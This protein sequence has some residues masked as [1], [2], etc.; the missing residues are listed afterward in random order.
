MAEQGPGG[1]CCEGWK[2]LR[3]QEP[4]FGGTV[5]PGAVCKALL[6]DHPL[7]PPCL[8]PAWM[9]AR[10]WNS[11]QSDKHGITGV[12]AGFQD[13]PGVVQ[14]VL[15]CRLIVL[16]QATSPSPFKKYFIYLTKRERERAPK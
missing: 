9:S 2:G 13:K 6:L 15:Y 4:I 11:R 8:V 7:R 12:G 1:Q 16:F 5:A 10:C 3:G 14:F